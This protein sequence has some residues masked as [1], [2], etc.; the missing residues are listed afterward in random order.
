MLYDDGRIRCDEAGL[1]I[2]WYYPWGAKRIP[3]DSIKSVKERPLTL[4]RGRWRLWGGGLKCWYN[5]DLTRPTKNVALEINVGGYFR[6][7][8]TPSDAAV[9]L[10]ILNDRCAA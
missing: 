2:G 10:Q 1:R 7:T 9:V 6:P 4:W 5:L 8:I 3:Y